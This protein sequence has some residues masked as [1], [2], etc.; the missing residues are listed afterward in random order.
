MKVERPEARSSEAP[1]RVKMASTGP[2]RALVAGTKQPTW[3]SSTISATWRIVVDLPPMLG[4][5][6]SSMR[7]VGSRRQSLA[8]KFSTW[9]STTGWRPALISM[10]G[11]S[12][13]TGIA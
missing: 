12:L 9:R 11:W 13:N 3:A 2:I 8:M 1:M 5:V 6:I 10:P 4:P 7:R